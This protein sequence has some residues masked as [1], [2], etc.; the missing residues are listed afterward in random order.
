MEAGR[1]IAVKFCQAVSIRASEN[2]GET[3]KLGRR[4]CKGCNGGQANLAVCADNGD[5]HGDVLLVEEKIVGVK[6]F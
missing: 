2:M 4:S 5:I 6:L 1:T 3:H